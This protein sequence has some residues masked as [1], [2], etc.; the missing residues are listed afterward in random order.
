MSVGDLFIILFL[1]AF[2]GCTIAPFHVRHATH[3]SAMPQPPALLA[4]GGGG[5]P[6]TAPAPAQAAGLTSALSLPAT[7]PSCCCCWVG[8]VTSTVPAATPVVPARAAFAK[9]AA[10]AP[11][12]KVPVAAWC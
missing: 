1:L 6:A 11:G 7:C 9:T 10:A 8:E 5:P 12:W 4:A 2:V 3:R